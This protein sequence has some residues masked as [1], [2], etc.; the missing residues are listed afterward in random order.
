MSLEKLPELVG[1]ISRVYDCPVEHI[2]TNL[3]AIDF[4]PAE[5]YCD[6]HIDLLRLQSIFA[7]DENALILIAGRPVAENVKEW[8]RMAARANLD[9]DQGP[10]DFEIAAI[11][12]GKI[13]GD[14]FVMLRLF[15]R[16]TDVPEL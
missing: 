5:G 16:K 8:R 2:V 7:S 13:L 1:I 10:D 4:W 3:G 11:A 14:H 15:L 12:M 9:V 6:P